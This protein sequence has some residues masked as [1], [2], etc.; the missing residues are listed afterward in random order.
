MRLALRPDRR[1][2][3]EP[4]TPHGDMLTLY[5]REYCHLCEDAEA[6]LASLR[7]AYR[8]IDIDTDLALTARYGLRVPVLRQ[9]SGKEIDGPFD[10]DLIAAWIAGPAT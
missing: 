10:P 5:F 7:I 8:R 4:A 1:N 2:D 3:R 6:M 9:E